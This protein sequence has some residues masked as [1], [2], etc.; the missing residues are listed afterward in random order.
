MKNLINTFALTLVMTSPLSIA[1]ASNPNDAKM[2]HLGSSSA[3]P[4]QSVFSDATHQ[5][6]VHVSGKEISELVIQLP[7][8]VSISR[9][10]DVKTKSGT[11]V[12]ANVSIN[13]EKARLV[14]SQP[15]APGVSI[16]VSMKG[17]ETPFYASNGHTWHYKVFATKVGMK[18]EISL[19]L[20]RVDIYPL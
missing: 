12:P 3:T 5:F 11:K 7:E 15:V 10:V 19:G 2:S 17:V 18:E 14:F 16:L 9:G 13:E 20:A 4:N 8:G 6:E 1:L